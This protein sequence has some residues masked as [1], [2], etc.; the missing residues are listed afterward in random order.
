MKSIEFDPIT[1]KVI[2]DLSKIVKIKDSNTHPIKI[3]KNDEGIHIKAG[4]AGRSV[5]FTLDAPS[6]NFNFEGEE[7]CFYDYNEFFSYINVFEAPTITQG[8][9]GEGNA[10]TEAVIISEGRRKLSYPLSDAEVIKGSLKNIKWDECDARFNFSADN[11]AQLKK[12]LS[13]LG[14]SKDN[15]IKMKFVGNEVTITASTQLN[16]NSYEDV[17]ELAEEV[18][19]DFELTFSDEVFKYLLNTDYRVEA[20]TNG[21]VRFFFNIRDISASILATT[22]GDDDE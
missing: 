19:T 7:I 8:T 10:E 11:L 12:I 15:E 20:Q 4:N 18:E 14:S 21:F 1:L 13:L 22:K 9:I 2:S 3:T 5:V 17:Y 16:K 6:Y